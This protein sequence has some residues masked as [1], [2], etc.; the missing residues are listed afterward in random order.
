ML[1]ARK[2]RRTVKTISFALRAAE[3][4]C[5]AE[6]VRKIAADVQREQNQKKEAKSNEAE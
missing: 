4:C 2:I 6:K 5:M 3:T 1:T